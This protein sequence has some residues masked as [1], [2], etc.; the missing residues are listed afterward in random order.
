M[1]LSARG[2]KTREELIR[3]ATL[4]FAAHGFHHTSMADLLEAASI[5]KGAFYH[6]FKSKQSLA[7][8]VL[9]QA[10][11]DYEFHIVAPLQIMAPR[12]RLLE[13]MR[14]TLEMDESRLWPATQLLA[15]MA[16]DASAITPEL[17][18]RVG[19]ILQWLVELWRI[20]LCDARQASVVRDDLDCQA[21]AEMIVAAWLGAAGCRELDER[22]LDLDRIAQQV[23]QLIC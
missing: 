2:A 5:S 20:T 21:T 18:E 10:L 7:G 14:R 13:L 3:T 6:H 1:T 17:A 9:E 4:Q 16:Q 23:L 22:P 15:R 12:E 8:A 19:H 11:L